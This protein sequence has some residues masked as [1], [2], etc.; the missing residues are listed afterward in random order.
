MVM[1]TK[2]RDSMKP[3]H[4]RLFMG[5]CI[6][7][8]GIFSQSLA[9]LSPIEKAFQGRKP[10]GEAALHSF[11]FKLYDIALW[12]E[13]AEC[14]S[15]FSC[16]IGIQTTQNWGAD[17]EKLVSKTLEK[18]KRYN[19]QL[20]EEE[21]ITYKRTLERV[22]PKRL[23]PGDM[24]Q[25]VTEPDSG[26]MSFYIKE[27]KEKDFSLKGTVE[28]RNFARHFFDIWLHPETTYSQLRRELL[29]KDV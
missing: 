27:K 3:L 29:G 26:N 10:L 25:V 14:A 7:S 5:L 11:I 19:P 13:N 23:D 21:V 6:L 20:T 8:T 22:Y 15:T 24:I 1:I 28:S 4:R 12:S 17:K 18:M 9:S 2:N 16:K